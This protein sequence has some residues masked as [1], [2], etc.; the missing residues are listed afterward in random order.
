MRTEVS[1]K[2][3]NAIKQRNSPFK[4]NNSEPAKLQS[5][6][7]IKTSEA[8]TDFWSEMTTHEENHTRKPPQVVFLLQNELNK[9]LDA[10]AF[11]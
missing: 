4:V 11:F 9:Y 10:P 6:E 1:V 7:F 5:L 2:N 8:E 3:W